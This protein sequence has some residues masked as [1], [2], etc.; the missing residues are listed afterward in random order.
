[1]NMT[2]EGVGDDATVYGFPRLLREAESVEFRNFCVMRCLM[3]LCLL[4]PKTH[5]CGFTHG[6]LH[7]KR[8]VLLTRLWVTGTVDTGGDSK[9]LPQLTNRFG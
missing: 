8:V 5:V 1:M 7:G 3:M 4:I 2:F 6:S 9:V